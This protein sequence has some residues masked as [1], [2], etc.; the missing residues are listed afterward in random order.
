MT[1]QPTFKLIRPGTMLLAVVVWLGCATHAFAIDSEAAAAELIA[2][3]NVSRTSNGLPALPR[4]ARLAAVAKSRSEDM[5]LRNYFDHVIPPDNRTVRDLLEALGVPG[6]ASENIAFNNALDFMTVQMAESDFMNSRG[7]RSNVLNGRWNRVGTG[8]A[9]GSG[10]RMYTVVFLQAPTERPG[11]PV[12]AAPAPAGTVRT[13]AQGVE[14]GPAPQGLIEGV[15]H[16]V[17][18]RFLYL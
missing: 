2:L 14:V 15:V 6:V 18:R 10:R 11:G 16:R 17:L 1:L 8:A 12:R 4:D 7:H 5:I 9:E 3:T 13:D